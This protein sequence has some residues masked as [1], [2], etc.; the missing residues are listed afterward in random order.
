MAA[1]RRN[2]AISR[3]DKLWSNAPLA[4]CYGLYPLLM[5]AS[6]ALGLGVPRNVIDL[7]WLLLAAWAAMLLTV[8]RSRLPL[9]WPA[10]AAAIAVAA[11]VRFAPAAWAGGIYPAPLVME[12]KPLLYLALAGLLWLAG[13]RP[14]PEDFV[15]WGSLLAG[16]LTLDLIAQSLL[17]GTVARP[18]GSGEINYDAALLVI[19]LCMG[20]RASTIGR[21]ALLVGVGILA[22][23]S[24]T[25]LACLVVIL[26]VQGM[27]RKNP[28]VLVGIALALGGVAMSFYAR[29]L[30]MSGDVLAGM[31]RYWMWLA[32]VEL[33]TAHPWSL[34]TGFL[35]G[36]PLPADIPPA[37]AALWSTQ[38]QDWR[39]VGVFAFNFHACWLRL[40][41]TWGL[42]GLAA[43]SALLLVPAW[44]LP[45]AGLEATL[46][47]ALLGTT[48][49]LVYL[50]NVAI[51]LLLALW[52]RE[53]SCP[54]PQA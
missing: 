21:D 18:Y 36:V 42:P 40:A 20:L 26:A 33:L 3:M 4:L 49:G 29:G 37:V 10:A 5:N 13:C 48:M 31:D 44:R 39:A 51:P 28:L 8:E 54:S 9:W 34:L 24:R 23:L 27:R 50:G 12:L 45:R 1:E 35:P 46:A 6:N 14:K 30:P 53:N 22:S 52:I 25:G 2:A 38:A 17:A 41:I 11:V 32:G 43:W 16:L 15:R 7:A 19:A 47:L